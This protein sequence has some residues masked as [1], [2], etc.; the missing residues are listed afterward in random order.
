MPPLAVTRSGAGAPLVLLHGI[1]SSRRAWDPVL[2]LL[3]A[4]GRCPGFEAAMAGTARRHFQATATVLEPTVLEPT[5]LE[6]TVPE[7]APVTIAFGSRDLPS[8]PS[9]PEPPPAIR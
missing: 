3:E 1:G 4:L 5:V 8:P 6:P 7:T 9:S 2:P